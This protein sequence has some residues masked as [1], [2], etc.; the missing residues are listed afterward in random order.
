M[1]SEQP[2]TKNVFRNDENHLVVSNPEPIE[3]VISARYYHWDHTSV[4]VCVSCGSLVANTSIHNQFHEG[5]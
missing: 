3:E 1:D 5:G 2:E 4:Q